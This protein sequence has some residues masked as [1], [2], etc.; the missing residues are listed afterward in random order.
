MI[1]VANKYY[2][3]LSEFGVD[4]AIDAGKA[5]YPD[6]WRICQRIG[7]EHGL[8]PRRVAAVMAVT[9]PRARWSTNLAAT[10]MLCAEHKAGTYSYSY[11]I[12]GA[13]ATKGVRV[14]ESRYY[15]NVISGPKVSAFYDAICGDTDSVTVDSI[16]SKA[17]GY[18]SDVS[19]RIR[20][21]VVQ[22]CWMIGDVFG[23][24]P[25]DAQAAVWVAYR[26]GAA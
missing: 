8:A 23:V 4:A 11:N 9:S 26:G 10:A 18:S 3:H 15:S 16:M 19:D 22:A 2:K 6:A 12:L 7:A 5:W 13:S 14:L 1:T 25:R 21:E 24:S 17:A 20:E